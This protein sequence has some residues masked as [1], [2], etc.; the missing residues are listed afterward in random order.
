MRKLVLYAIGLIVLCL[1]SADCAFS[2]PP[3]PTVGHSIKVIVSAANNQT[4]TPM[5][6]EPSVTDT[7]TSTDVVN[8][9]FIDEPPTIDG[10]LDEAVWSQ[11]QP[12]TYAV[13]PLVNDRTTVVVR[14]LGDNRYLYAGFDISDTQVEGSA[15]TEKWN[16]DSVSTV[17]PFLQSSNSAGEFVAVPQATPPCGL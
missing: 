17:A 15:S 3:T 4:P 6:T 14:L 2:P 9:I 10:R 7:P 5:P 1:C 12:L 8:A 13:Y 16:G 11:A